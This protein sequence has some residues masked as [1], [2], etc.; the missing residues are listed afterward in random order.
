M[1]EVDVMVVTWRNALLKGG[2][3]LRRSQI[4]IEMPGQRQD[5]EPIP[6]VT[7]DCLGVAE[8]TS[9]PKGIIYPSSRALILLQISQHQITPRPKDLGTYGQ[10]G[11][12]LEI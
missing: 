1:V 11:R 9:T 8:E 2:F 5:S 3:K 6:L 10:K 12:Y 4:V 7:V